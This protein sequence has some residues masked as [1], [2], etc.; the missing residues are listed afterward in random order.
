[1]YDHLL[2]RG[3]KHF[4][5]YCSHTFITEDISNHHI[6]DCFK[7]IGKQAF[8][9]P[10]KGGY[11]K[12]KNFERKIKLPFMIFANFESILVPEDNKK[13]NPNITNILLGVM[14]IN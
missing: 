8:M 13:E 6:K 4:C 9:M 2:H 3:R 5:R 12:F 11:V 7:T 14:T 10:L 1:M